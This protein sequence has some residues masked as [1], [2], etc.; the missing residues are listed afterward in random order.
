MTNFKSAKFE[1]K[2][3]FVYT[4]YTVYFEIKEKRTNSVDPDE[5]AHYD[6]LISLRKRIFA[7]CKFNIFSFFGTLSIIAGL[8]KLFHM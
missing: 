2:K 1:E 7:I 6:Y 5:A 8:L 4:Y 3:C